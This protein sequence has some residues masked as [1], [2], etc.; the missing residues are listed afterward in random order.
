MSAVAG[1]EPPALVDIRI[2][3]DDA[4]GVPARAGQ[5]DAEARAAIAASGQPAFGELRLPCI[6]QHHPGEM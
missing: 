1:I 2:S 4:H 6:G 5:R 3:D